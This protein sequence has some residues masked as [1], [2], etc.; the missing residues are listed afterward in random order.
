MLRLGRALFCDPRGLFLDVAMGAIDP[1]TGVQMRVVLHSVTP[2]WCCIL[3]PL[4]GCSIMLP[5]LGAVF[6]D[7]WVV[8]YSVTYGWCC[9]LWPLCGSVLHVPS[10]ELSSLTFGW[11]CILRPLGGAVC[12]LWHL[13]VWCCILWP[14]GGAVFYDFWDGDIFC[15]LW[16][17]A[18]FC[19]P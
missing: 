12:I 13:G 19:D 11:C 5:V 14:Q 3:W 4:V 16:D 1:W 8:L 6:S 18:V 9:I 7:A 2:G 17:G 15:D 10:V